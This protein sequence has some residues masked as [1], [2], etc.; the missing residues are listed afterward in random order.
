VRSAAPRAGGAALGDQAVLGLVAGSSVSQL[1]VTAGS[2]ASTH[3]LITFDRASSSSNPQFATL[4]DRVVFTASDGTDDGALWASDGANTQRLATFSHLAA[5]S[6]SVSAPV[7]MGGKAFVFA[8]EPGA[9][10][11]YRASLVITDG[12]PA[13]TQRIAVLGDTYMQAFSEFGG[14]LV[15]VLESSDRQRVT[16]WASDGTAAGTKPLLPL[17]PTGVTRLV[18]VGGLLYFFS[19]L[20]DSDSYALFRSDGTAAGTASFPVAANNLGFDPEV[21]TAAGQLFFTAGGLLYRLDHDT[22]DAGTFAGFTEVMGLTEHDGRLLFFGIAAGDSPQGGCGA[23]T[24][25]RRERRSWR[26]LRRSLRGWSSAPTACR[27]GRA[28]ATTSSSGDGTPIT[29]SS[30]GSRMGRPA[31][32]PGWISCRGAPPPSRTTSLWRPAASGSRPMTPSTAAR[33]G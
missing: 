11:I 29:A 32:R 20:N 33:S 28:S 25:R 8:G 21:A 18:S 6:G 7:V 10:G 17:P 2:A 14:R 4:G 22:V 24:A 3:S 9:D 13:G 12:T 19:F 1:W 30:C 5:H 23:P 31:A 27:S 15:F 26:G 16:L